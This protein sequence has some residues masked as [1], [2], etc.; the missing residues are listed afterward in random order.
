MAVISLRLS[1]NEEK[2][3]DLLS[4]FYKEDKSALIKRSLNEMYEDLIDRRVIEEYETRERN[5]TVTF[6]SP[7]EIARMLKQPDSNP[8]T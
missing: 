6:V 1:R 7:E 3:V 2:M 8:P 4:G 5:G